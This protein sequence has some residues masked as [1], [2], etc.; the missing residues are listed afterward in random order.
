MVPIEW[1]LLAQLRHLGLN[2]II[3]LSNNSTNPSRQRSLFTTDAW[4]ELKN[5]V[6][7][8]HEMRD[9]PAEIK[10]K[11]KEVE[12]LAILDI[13]KL[14]RPVCHTKLSTHFCRK[15]PILKYT[16]M[17]FVGLTEKIY[18]YIDNR[19]NQPLNKI[20]LVK[21]DHPSSLPF[22]AMIY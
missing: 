3:D 9:T 2:S 5:R 12:Q 22:S 4:K 7:V 11:L 21:F 13:R 18:L 14:T 15:K 20:S 8:S 6:Y 19:L 17:F 10:M 16:P 1:L